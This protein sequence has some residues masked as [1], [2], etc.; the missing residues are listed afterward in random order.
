MPEWIKDIIVAVGGGSVVLLGVLTIFK[1]LVIKSFETGIETIFQKNIEKYRDQLS[2]SSRAYE[3]ILNKEM[4][5]YEKVDLIFAELV[6]LAHSIKRCFD[7]EEHFESE[8][9]AQCFWMYLQQYSELY[10]KLKTAILI[11]QAY[12]PEEI[13]L[14]YTALSKTMYDD[15]ISLLEL[16][17]ATFAEGNDVDNEMVQKMFDNFLNVLIIPSALV[18]KR[19]QMLSS[20]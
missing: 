10:D 19:L 6:P 5:F 16:G 4:D 12:I 3:M 20:I 7:K 15:T 13:L 14:S 9:N 2:R 18:K 17:K 1:Q 11:H 8:K